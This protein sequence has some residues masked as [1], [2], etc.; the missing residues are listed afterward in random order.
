MRPSRGTLAVLLGVAAAAAGCGSSGA[1]PPPVT[2]AAVPRSAALAVSTAE[3]QPALDPA[4][5]STPAERSL[6]FA[7]CTPLVTYADASGD[8][9]RTPIPGLAQDLPFVNPTATAFSFTLKPRLMFADGR[10]LTTVDLRYTFERLLSPRLHSPAAVLFGDV[11]GARAFRAGRSDH[12][13]GIDITQRS[14]TFHLT[15]GDPSFL[16]RVALPATC[17]VEVGTPVAAQ[18]A[19]VM[20]SLATGPYRVG[21]YTPGRSLTLVRNG[22]YAPGLLG[23][24][25]IAPRI[26]VTLGAAP[27]AANAR[28]GD[29][30]LDGIPAA[31][32]RGPARPQVLARD[33]QGEPT[34]GFG[35]LA[36][37]QAIPPFETPNV[38]RAV[39]AAVGRSAVAQ[40]AGGPLV[41]VPGTDLLS[42]AIPGA[43]PSGT[44]SPRPDV[45]LARSL[46][47]DAGVTPPLRTHLAA[48]RSLAPVARV[49][50]G[51][52]RRAGIR[53]ALVLLRPGQ[54]PPASA[55]LVLGTY[56]PGYLDPIDVIDAVYG[57]GLPAERG[58]LPLELGDSRLQ[59]ALAVSRRQA[60][61]AR[62]ETLG[63]LAD[64]LQ[65]RDPR[66]AVLWYTMF[67]VLPARRVEGLVTHPVYPVDLAAMAALPSA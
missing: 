37:D 42:P 25:G 4:F 63:L 2:H 30:D 13:S 19:T 26:D 39:S 57:D 46:L 8:A 40:A 20:R 18:P 64:R 22:R 67:S 34:G 6:A 53:P 35:Y 59:A 14:I 7:L 51:Q 54:A 23:R 56:Q 28:E 47:L 12:V 48:P 45:A 33:A 1:P 36:I 55:A 41:A 50:V 58:P 32:A 17:P 29:I 38:R 10:P 61:D 21:A 9:G 62:V 52:L 60:G 5:A 15:R 11:V 16:R 66:L 3:R 31:A 44:G 24:R 27:P 65:A 49:L 43:R